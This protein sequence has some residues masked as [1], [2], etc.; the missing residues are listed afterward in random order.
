MA[1]QLGVKAQGEF[2]VLVAEGEAGTCEVRL[3]LEE[4]ERF[5]EALD[6]ARKRALMASE[7]RQS[8]EAIRVKD[9]EDDEEE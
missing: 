2:V 6:K 3:T 4:V 7:A 9:V 8:R 1:E 5:E